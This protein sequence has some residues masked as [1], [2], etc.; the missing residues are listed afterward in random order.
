MTK[1]DFELF[2]DILVSCKPAPGPNRDTDAESSLYEGQVT[3]YRWTCEVAASRL[4]ATNPRFDKAR[5]L[6]A[7]GV[8]P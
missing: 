8:T 6:A 5:F 2:A 1:K 7:C 3:Q 4:R